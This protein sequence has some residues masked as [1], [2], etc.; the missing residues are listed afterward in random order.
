MPHQLHRRLVTLILE[1]RSDYQDSLIEDFLFRLDRDAAIDEASRVIDLKLQLHG[2]NNK[3]D[4]LP[5]A[6]H[7]QT[8][9]QRMATA[10]K[11][12]GETLYSDTHDPPLTTEQRTQCYLS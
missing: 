12:G 11:P 1:V 4:N 9:Y 3:Q 8:E 10:F 2:N 6:S 7:R 5:E